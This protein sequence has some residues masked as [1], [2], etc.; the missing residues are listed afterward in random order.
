MRAQ[1]ARTIPHLDG[2]DDEEYFFHYTTRD[3]AFGAIL[4]QR[5]LR[6]SPYEHMRDPLENKEWWFSGMAFG[7]LAYDEE[8]ARQ[9]YDSFHRHANEIRRSAKLLSLTLSAPYEDEREKVFA[10]GWARA[11]MW[12]QYAERH[13]GVCLVF[14]KDALTEA[15][16]SSLEEQGAAQPYHRAVR[17]SASPFEDGSPWLD[18]RTLH[19]NS[20]PQAVRQWVQQHHDGLFFHKAPDW[21]TEHE[22][23]FVVTQP[24]HAYMYADFGDSLASVIVGER[25][26]PWQM[27]GATGTCGRFGI[28]VRCVSWALGFPSLSQWTTAQG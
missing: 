15:I 3:A 14:K 21:Q 8:R 22:Y 5:R 9:A 1:D 16:A 23:R 6:F 17:Y 19:E 13:A 25:F 10:Q 12:E 4:P 2:P 18:F 24:H 20:S 7:R 28:Q 11:R 27:A 26:P